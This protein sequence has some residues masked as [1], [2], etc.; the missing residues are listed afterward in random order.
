[1]NTPLLY[2]MLQDKTEIVRFLLENGAN[3]NIPN[4]KKEIY[5]LDFAVR[6]GKR[7]NESN[8]TVCR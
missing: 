6:N 1:M 8:S 4:L 2:A 3:P 7:N 5:P